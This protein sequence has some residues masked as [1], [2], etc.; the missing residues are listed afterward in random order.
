MWTKIKHPKRHDARELVQL[1]QK[2][3]IREFDRQS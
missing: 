1:S 2:K 3:G